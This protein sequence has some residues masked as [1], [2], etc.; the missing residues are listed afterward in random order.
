MKYIIARA[1]ILKMSRCLRIKTLLNNN[2]IL[3]IYPLCYIG[4]II[5][6]HPKELLIIQNNCENYQ[7]KLKSQIKYQNMQN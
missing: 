2:I 4:C 6:K 3:Y 5:Q 1:R 7:K